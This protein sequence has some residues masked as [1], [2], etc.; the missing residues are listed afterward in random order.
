MIVSCEIMFF[1][2]VCSNTIEMKM[3]VVNGTILQNKDFTNRMSEEEYL[4]NRQNWWISLNKFG[5]TTRTSEKTFWFQPSVVYIKPFTPRSWT[6]TAQAHAL[7]E[8]L[9]MA[10]VNE[11]FLN[12]VAME[13]ILVVFLRI[14]K[15]VNER[16]CKQRFKIERSNPLS[17]DLW[18]N[19]QTKGFHEFILFCDRWIVYSWRRSYC[20]RRGV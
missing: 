11:F 4:H 10:T 8:V 17:T 15:K 6:T 3:F 16:G 19:P 18:V 12:L 14:Q 9:G 13:W 5:N 20:N 1:V 7:L 2:N